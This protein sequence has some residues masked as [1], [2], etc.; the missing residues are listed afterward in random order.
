M[1]KKIDPSK[2]WTLNE[3]DTVVLEKKTDEEARKEKADMITMMGSQFA[4]ILG[5]QS[6]GCHFRRWIIR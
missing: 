3:A 5:D 4:C 2:E 1:A 6:M